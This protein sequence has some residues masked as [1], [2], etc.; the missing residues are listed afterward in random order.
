MPYAISNGVKLY[1]EEVGSGFPIVFVHEF[2]SDLR[3]W[4]QQ[5]RYFSREFRCIA[6]NA[7]GYKP[8]DIPKDSPALLA[9]PWLTP[10][11][12]Y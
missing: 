4:E 11:S 2:G 12:G 8:S 5:L 10:A 6:F 3:E 7:R 1:Y 9:Q